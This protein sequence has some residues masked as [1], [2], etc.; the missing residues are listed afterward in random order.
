VA[1]DLGLVGFVRNER[2]GSVYV[3]AEGEKETLD[4]FVTW[5]RQG[6]PY[7]QVENVQIASGPV[8]GFPGFAIR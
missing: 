4:R 6:P 7:A 3:E 8:K 2:D 1:T 5:L